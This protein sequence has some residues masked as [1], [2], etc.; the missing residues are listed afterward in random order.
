MV[1]SRAVFFQIFDERSIHRRTHTVKGWAVWTG[2]VA[3]G[4]VIAFIIGES[5]PFFNDLLSLI[6]SLFDS[7]FGVSPL[8][9]PLLLTCPSTAD[10]R[11]RSTSCL[12]RFPVSNIC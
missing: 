8:I 10:P 1:T 2:I 4:W 7:W 5:I 3:V 9:H 11:H 6:S 12:A